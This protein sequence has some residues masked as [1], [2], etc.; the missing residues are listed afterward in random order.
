MP[1]LGGIL[2]ESLRRSSYT[3][4]TQEQ[5]HQPAK[6]QPHHTAR[7]RV[8]LNAVA[9]SGAQCYPRLACAVKVAIF[10]QLHLGFEVL[11][12]D[13]WNMFFWFD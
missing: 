2:S 13:E 9:T 4:N 12:V 10:M 3:A 11:Q 8:K 6:Q 1:P 7:R 5:K